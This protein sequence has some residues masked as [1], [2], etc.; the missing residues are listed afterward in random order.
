MNQAHN[1]MN[2]RLRTFLTCLMLL[3]WPFAEGIGQC[4]C[5]HII[6]PE[7]VYI[8]GDDPAYAFAPGDV[9]CLEAST[10]QELWILNVHGAPGNPVTFVNC[11]GPVLIQQPNLY[12][13]VL[14]VSDS[15]HIRVSGSGEPAIPY[16]IRIVGDGTLNSGSGVELD[17]LYNQVEL[18][19]LE[20][21][22]SEFAGIWAKEMGFDCNFHR[23]NFTL[24]DLHIHDNYIHDI[25]TDGIYIS[26]E[27]ASYES[28][29]L[30][31]GGTPR[32][33][34]GLEG[35]RVY[36]NRIART[37]WDGIEV[38][39]ANWD[40]E[41]HGNTITEFG[42]AGDPGQQKGIFLVDGTSGKC[43]NNTLRNGAG[44]GIVLTG[45]GTNEVYNNL[46]EGLGNMGIVCRERFAPN[47]GAYTV[48][49]NTIVN[50]GYDGI[51][52][53]S[54]I[55][56][57]TVL[58]NLVINPSNIEFIT[59]ADGVSATLAGN[60]LD[61]NPGN[62][63]F[64]D[65]A[66]GDYRLASNSPLI[67][68]GAD[69]SAYGVSTDHDE[70]NRL[71]HAGYDLGA[72]EFQGTPTPPQPPKVPG[73]PA[74]TALDPNS[75]PPYD[76]SFRYGSNMGFYP[77]WTD[78]QLAD[79][80][81]G[82]P[83]QGQEGIGVRSFRPSLQ[84]YLVDQFGYRVRIETFEHYASLGM[85][86][87]TLFI[88]FPADAGGHRDPNTYCPGGTQS[89]LFDNLYEPIWDN[90]EGGT[91]VNEANYYARYVWKL[92][93]LYRDYVR[94]WQVINE[95][96]FDGGGSG[97]FPPASEDP[98]FAA[99][100]WWDN[101]PDPCVL[102]NM[103]A[104]VQHYIRMLR[105][106]YEIV[107]SLAPDDYVC[108]GGIG[109]ESFLDALLRNTDN[110]GW[111][112]PEGVGE[113]GTVDATHYPLT[114]GAYFDVLT[115]HLYPQFSET[116]RYHDGSGF[117]YQRHSDAAA[118]A[119]AA[120]KADFEQ[121][122]A[123]RGY[124][125]SVY[126]A[127]L[128]T[129]TEINISREPFPYTDPG[130]AGEQYIG[131][132]EVQRNFVIKA[133]VHAQM[134]GIEQMYFY[135]LGDAAW[136][137][138]ATSSFNLMGLFQKLSDTPPYSQQVNSAGM[139]LRT[140]STE[141]FG[142][143]FD[144]ARTA[145]LNLPAG[146]RGA[147]FQNDQGAYKYVL[148]AETTFDQSEFASATYSFPPAFGYGA[149]ALVRKAWDE[150]TNP[151]ST[152]VSGDN[153]A[154]SGAP[155]LFEELAS[156]PFPVEFLSFT[157]TPEDHR[158]LLEWRTGS[159]KNNAHFTIERSVD[160]RLFESLHNVPSQ[161]DSDEVQAYQVYDLQPLTGKSYYRL[162]QTDLDGSF[163]Y[164]ETVSVAFEASQQARWQVH[165]NPL[166]RGN[167]LTLDLSIPR[168]G[169]A[170]LIL[171]NVLGQT[172]LRKDLPLVVGEQ[173]VEW[174][175]EP[176]PAGYYYLILRDANVIDPHFYL[177]QRILIH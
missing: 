92:V 82:N 36:N 148:W 94:F 35:L 125:G 31:C 168:A 52:V 122:L 75:I 100:N 25:G 37:G 161:G 30:D 16:G 71:V 128:W 56:A 131:G 84:E 1:P 51:V 80:A 41:I 144:A 9:V 78:E 70:N 19:H 134:Q 23:D 44:D 116:V 62:V 17:G 33:P 42:L 126:P 138:E 88:G 141:L 90:G 89:W 135:N 123:D 10:K 43:Y 93:Y 97:W 103:Q 15:D 50:T 96:D 106:T 143:S 176:L 2:D 67:D 64:V 39:A 27:N 81:A 172:M 113:P 54:A 164:S 40:A 121:V 177:S 156:D 129:M 155:S 170:Q 133:L 45:W 166:A 119:I 112:N 68:Q 98:A 63:Q 29:T 167:R 118:D 152:L 24:Y 77:G 13:Y 74:F 12:S 140:M 58:N 38:H 46:M 3:A 124:D 22:N 76:G 149:Q 86:D 139:A 72:Y 163:S 114:G 110:P 157:A 7:V 171:V 65:T 109:Y 132:D 169:Y 151:A 111:Y 11:N 8:N 165:P 95:P 115:F 107:K 104:P 130:S 146:V 14:K 26:R 28:S 127:K 137:Y 117:V 102:A 32:A 175:L 101:D 49:N 66:T 159:E 47:Y 18:D 57:N 160:A 85:D 120:K 174:D 73:P 150:A 55:T 105:I 6:A 87:H 60:Y 83:A 20:I 48:F 147:A 154:L 145:A 162:K 173:Q 4:N 59:L 136:D 158:V 153:L 61:M 91:P 69:I 79:I 21:S 99:A 53:N 108:L 142:F 5:D 34:Y